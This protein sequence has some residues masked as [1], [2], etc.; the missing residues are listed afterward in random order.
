MNTAKVYHSLNDWVIRKDGTLIPVSIVSAPLLR[1]G[2]VI[3]SVAAFQDITPRLDAEKSLRESEARFRNALENAPIGMA[4]VSLDGRFTEVNQALCR[5]LGYS[6]IELVELSFAAITHPDDLKADLANVDRLLGGEIHSYQME[7]R[8][9]RKDGETVWAQLT[10]SILRD[11]DRKPLYF[12]AQVEDITERKRQQE[13]IRQLAFY[14][15]LTGLP[16]RRL[17]LD[18]FEQALTQAQRYHRSLAVMFLDLDQF[19]QV[20]DTLGHDVG[21]ELLEQ[22]A[23]RLTSSVRHGDTVSRQGGDEFVVMLAEIAHPEDAAQVA[24]KILNALRLPFTI[25]GH[26]VKI[27]VS[28]GIAIYPVDGTDDI[29]ELMKKADIAMYAAKEG[30]RNQYHF[31]HS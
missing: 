24:Q 4:I 21:D 23:D 14:D 20:N 13:Q 22:V 9:I 5:I 3:G 8:Y 15:T 27:G 7:K 18:H 26:K 31:F 28:I 29:Q 2:R 17:F 6:R 10:G 16:N 19:K 30:G 25:K 12:L 11:A 1:D